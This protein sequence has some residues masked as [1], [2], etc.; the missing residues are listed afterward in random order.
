LAG[1]WSNSD[2]EFSQ[3]INAQNGTCNRSLQKI[4]SEKF[5]LELNSLGTKPQE[6]IGNPF[7]NLTRGPDGPLFDVHGTMLC[8]STVSTK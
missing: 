2:F 1:L 6:G 8:V 4:G 3:K 5:V 7:A